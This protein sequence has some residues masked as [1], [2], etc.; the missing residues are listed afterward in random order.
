MCLV[1]DCRL[2][3]LLFLLVA[4]FLIN[5]FS[6]FCFLCIGIYQPD[7][8]CQTS[9]PTCFVKLPSLLVFKYPVS[10][11]HD[12]LIVYSFQ[13]I[14]TEKLWYVMAAYLLYKCKQLC[15]LKFRVVSPSLIKNSI[16]RRM[17]CALGAL[18][19]NQRYKKKDWA[20]IDYLPWFHANFFIRFWEEEQYQ[21]WTTGALML[22]ILPSNVTSFY[23]SKD[24]WLRW[25]K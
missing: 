12:I 2:W 21:P 11:P 13:G 24:F 5:N 7:M 4:T 14:R 10:S 20:S 6:I 3:F 16:Y 9:N 22:A 15:M 25:L 17:L 1:F 18:L 19:T 23:C 8:F